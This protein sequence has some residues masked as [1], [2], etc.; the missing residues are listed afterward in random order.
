MKKTLLFTFSTFALT[1]L[2][3][4][5]TGQVAV[6]GLSA[7]D[8]EDEC[9]N[10][11]KKLIKVDKFLTVLER[12]SAFHLEEAALA[13]EVPGVTVSNNKPRMLKDANKRR[14]ELLAEHQK[15]GCEP[16]EK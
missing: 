3:T 12:N 10:L 5:C 8:K 15:L 2:M 9:I 11:D 13:M 16:L 1:L 4:G 6:P 14:T 7:A